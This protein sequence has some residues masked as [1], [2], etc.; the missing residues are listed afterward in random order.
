MQ[1]KTHAEGDPRKRGPGTHA[2]EAAQRG[3]HEVGDIM[4]VSRIVL[5]CHGEQG[6]KLSI[7]VSTGVFRTSVFRLFKDPQARSRQSRHI[8]FHD[9]KLNL[10]SIYLFVLALKP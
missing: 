3:C 1:K 5:I 10:L 7:P 2:D 8:S 9:L 6:S 4:L